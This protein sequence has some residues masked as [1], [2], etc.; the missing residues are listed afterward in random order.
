M[1]PAAVVIHYTWWVTLMVVGV[2]IST[3]IAS[4]FD[5][6]SVHVNIEALAHG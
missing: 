1:E 3:Y 4:T 5:Y 2:T 6:A